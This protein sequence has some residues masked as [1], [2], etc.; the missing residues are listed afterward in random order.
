MDERR[1]FVTAQQLQSHWKILPAELLDFIHSGLPA[2][3]QTGIVIEVE[4]LLPEKTLFDI[5]KELLLR[6][7]K[8]IEAEK[9]RR[10]ITLANIPS[11]FHPRDF[12]GAIGIVPP[13]LSDTTET[14]GGVKFFV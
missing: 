11:S 4:E 6:A 10:F 13:N 3:Q 5:T 2:Y 8:N 14:L 12:K 1:N 7:V 9:C